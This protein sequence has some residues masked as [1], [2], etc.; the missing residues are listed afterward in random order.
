MNN[1][2]Q[3][4]LIISGLF[5]SLL[6]F[7]EAY[8]VYKYRGISAKSKVEALYS[9]SFFIVQMVLSSQYIFDENFLYPLIFSLFIVFAI[10]L[11]RFFVTGQVIVVKHTSKN[12]IVERVRSELNRLSISFTE[13][14]F[15]LSDLHQFNLEDQTVIKVSNPWGGEKEFKTYHLSFKK[16]WR[17][18]EYED[19]KTNIIEKYRVEREE[20]VYWKQ[21]LFSIG[22]GIGGFILMGFLAWRWNLYY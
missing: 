7:Y 17:L 9:F 12:I 14:G 21:I 2:M 3:I 11:Y 5:A 16:W 13:E 22:L 8:R 10:I 19:I 4:F 6:Y 20:V 18:Y 1:Y 15:D